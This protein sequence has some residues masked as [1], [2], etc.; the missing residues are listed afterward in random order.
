MGLLQRDA[1]LASLWRQLTEVRSGAGRLIVVDGPAG[2]GKSSLLA[3]TAAA[4]AR[5]GM[6]TLRAA[7][8]PLEQD[9]GWG[10][11]R[12]VFAALRGAEWDRLA[13]GAAALARR[14]LDADEAEPVRGGDAMHAATHGLTWL[15]AGVAEQPPT[16]M[17]VDDVHWADPPSLR[18]LAG[19][20]RQLADLPL[21]VLC[22]VRSGEPPSD[23]DLL[24]ELLATAP[25]PPVR[26]GPLGSDA[27]ATVVSARLPAAE[28]AFA[29][30]CHAATAG[31]PFLL[32]ALI[33]HIVAER[34]EPTDAVA[35]TL[36]TFG[37]EQVARSVGRLLAR[38]PAGAAALARAFAV[39]GRDAPLRHAGE[40]AELSADEVI[41]L[42][43]R[44]CA[45]GLLD[46][47]G[48]RWFLVHPLVAAA[49]HA[50]LPAGELSRWHARTARLLHAER[51]DPETV[52]LHL[53]HTQPVRDAATVDTLREAAARAA[54][55][56]APQSAVVFLQRALAEPPPTR[57]DEAEVRSELALSLA[58][59][60]RPDAPALLATA[61]ELAT[62]AEQRSRIALSGAR[63][64]G[65]VGRFVEA[66]QLCRVGLDRAA[67]IAPDRR[68][69]LEAELIANSWLDASTVD[70]A[71]QRLRQPAAPHDDP[72]WQV[73]TACA[74]LFDG[75]P[76]T[77]TLARL[78]PALDS[79]AIDGTVVGT[80]AKFVLIDSGDLDTARAQCTALI[81]VARPQGWLVAL[82]HGSFLRALADIRAGR[83]RDAEAD[84]RFAYEFKLPISP[85]PILMWTALPFVEALTQLDEL[86][87]AQRVLRTIGAD[88]DL[89]PG[90]LAT[91]HLLEA[92]GRLSLARHQP[93]A[94]HADL[95]AAGDLW[96]AF[97]AAHPGLAAWRVDAAEALVALGDRAAAR[98]L[99]Q[100]H[101]EL[102][103][104]V[105]LP[106]AR[107]DG[108]RAL[109]RTPPAPV[110]HLQQAAALLDG[111]TE[112]LE[113]TRV[114]VDL[115]AALR[116]GNQ[117]VAA[118]APLR[119]ALA[120]ADRGGMRLLARR[121]RHELT[122]A[123]ARP[124]RA[125]VTGSA[126]LTSAEH[127]VATLAA[128]GCSNPEIAQR[129]YVTRRTVETHLTHV[130]A[131]LG[132]TTRADLTA[133]LA[134]DDRRP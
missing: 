121:A 82:T 96:R 1:E 21:A 41:G 69:Q 109:A 64:L 12:Q 94:A 20:G 35:A 30:A 51:A 120:L 11:A 17:V 65:L 5:A 87:E 19:L 31:N 50:Q 70:A 118:R 27:V 112:R 73:V 130:Y 86:D 116:R 72:A 36:R 39:L 8:S 3:A 81:E 76:A 100:E 29:T 61:V 106:G 54:V 80:L 7:G 129:L 89:P 32:G 42:A 53:L 9:A 55:R 13:V 117:R 67:G 24:D 71:R 45:A 44:L 125:A 103:D 92:R 97:G 46:R 119:Q 62:T 28:P 90:L 23:A 108:L 105:R 16:L 6:R 10:V 104:R 78:A 59:Q 133:S 47:D 88:G 14:A 22:A 43:D 37:P 74:S 68:V 33:N 52:A 111:S 26:P 34:V 18:W 66:A 107:A 122:A 101:L 63:A 99:A 95:C 98:R 131:K 110:E 48:D 102:A 60:V 123:G 2:I 127:R 134:T 113:H 124:R 77:E 38:L 126:A 4:A 56:G 91:A 115:G 132:V 79:G 25:E 58:A 15:A 85:L 57:A 83:I 93:G 40:L 84:A 75:V 49:L 128:Q 114:L